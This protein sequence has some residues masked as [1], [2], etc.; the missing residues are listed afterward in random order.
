MKSF[1]PPQVT[2]TTQLARLRHPGLSRNRLYDGI[3][4]GALH[5]VRVGRRIIID[6]EALDQ[7]VAA[8]CPGS[9]QSNADAD[10][11]LSS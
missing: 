7:W 1:N 9:G 2:L 10:M 8:G 5:S 4:S 11:D 6:T 3:R